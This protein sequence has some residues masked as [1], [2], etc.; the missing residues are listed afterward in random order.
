[1]RVACITDTHIAFKK[2]NQNFHN[3]FEKFYNDIFFPELEKRK[4]KT[5]I[6]LGDAFDNRK[7]IDYWGLE[8]AQRVVY[9]RFREL[10]ITVYQICGNHDASMRSTNKYNA[11]GTLLRDYDNVVPIVEPTEYIIG[12]DNIA[13]VPWICKDNEDVT[14]KLLQDTSAK[15][16]FGHLELTGFTLFPGQINTHGMTVER[17]Q[18]FDRVFSG[19]YHTRSSDGKVFYLGNPYQMFWSDVDDERGFHI[20]DTE[21][22]DLE[23]IPNPYKI[24]KKLNYDN[25]P[26][27][28]VDFQILENKFVKLIV[29]NKS[30]Q[31]DYDTFISKLTSTNILDLKIVE[32]IQLEDDNVDITELEAEDTLTTLNK[33]IDGSDFSLDKD[34]VKKILHQIYYEALEVE[35]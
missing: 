34:M 24:Y 27:E 12:N 32:N 35:V 13:F 5:V 26:I 9:D 30:N 25:T 11:I 33:Y 10:E 17:F 7:G 18:K 29:K 14:F 22:Y 1:M 21:T 15:L 28:E 6:H 23:F 2:S 16:L 20:F 8:W 19:H 31:I 3:Y 4:I